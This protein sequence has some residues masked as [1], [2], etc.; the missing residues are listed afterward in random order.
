MR[1]RIF[2][3]KKKELQRP[4]SKETGQGERASEK[5]IAAAGKDVRGLGR[6]VIPLN[7][8]RHPVSPQRKPQAP[9]SSGTDGETGRCRLAEMLREE[10]TRVHTMALVLEVAET[11]CREEKNDPKK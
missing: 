4:T 3:R 2:F 11:I 1:L 10:R 7:P 6:K 8:D 5:S 9:R